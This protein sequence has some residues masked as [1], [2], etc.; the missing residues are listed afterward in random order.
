MKV[1]A[2]RNIYG[3]PGSKEF[4]N[5]FNVLHRL[6]ISLILVY[7]KDDLKLLLLQGVYF[8]VIEVEGTEKYEK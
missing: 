6:K 7:R 8:R 3:T 5:S 2:N 4:N 1:S